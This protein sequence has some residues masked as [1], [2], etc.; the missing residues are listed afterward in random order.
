MLQINLEA[1]NGCKLCEKTCP[2]AAIIV[3]NKK[4][5]VLENCTL[6]GACV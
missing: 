2:F 4:A 6:C 1:C 5:K 3:E